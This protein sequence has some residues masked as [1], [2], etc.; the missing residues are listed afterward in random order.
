LESE[1]RFG[2]YHIVRRIHLDEKQGRGHTA[3]REVLEKVYAHFLNLASLC[4]DDFDACAKIDKKLTEALTSYTRK[5][6]KKFRKE[7]KKQDL[8]PCSS[9]EAIFLCC[10]RGVLFR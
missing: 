10:G 4:A 6:L 8:C 9:G 5:I 7:F 3:D 1:D 2:V